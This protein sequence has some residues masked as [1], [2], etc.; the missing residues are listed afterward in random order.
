MKTKITVLALG[1]LVFALS[2]SGQA[3]QTKDLRKIG[4]LSR[5][6]HPSDSRAP[7]PQNLKAF[8]K[9]LAELGYVEGKNL[10][11]EFRYAE[12]RLERLP[13]LT[14]ELLR[15]KVEIIVTD[16]TLSA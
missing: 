16:S 14:E 1:T 4:Y 8:L 11:I 10:T 13:A 3:Q 2:L 7:S 6:L 9:G 5:E 12:G 15:L